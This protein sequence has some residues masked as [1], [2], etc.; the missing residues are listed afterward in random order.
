MLL[1]SSTCW[2]IY[3]FA[4]DFI[5]GIL[6]RSEKKLSR[7][8]NF[9]F[10]YIDDVLSLN[11]SK[12]G[13]FV[14]RIY[15]TELEI[16]YTTDTARCAS[17][18]DI[19]LEIDNEERLRTKHYDKRDYFNFFIVNFPFIG[20]NIPTATAYGVFICQLIDIPELVV[21]IRISLID[22]CCKQRNYWTKCS[23]VK[24]K[25]SL[26][27]FYG[28]NHDLVNRYGISESQMT[29]DMFHLS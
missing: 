4:F 13:D 19:Y 26:P 6:K 24:L 7:S 25:S 27:V 20:S 12:F 22:G 2:C 9:T 5:Q 23:I 29:T 17:Y 21:H 15:P 18:M 1:F 28:R 14:D 11:N 3:S 8:F 10:R 16:K